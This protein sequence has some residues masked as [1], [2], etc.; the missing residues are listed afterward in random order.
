MLSEGLKPG[1]KAGAY[2]HRDQINGKLKARRHARIAAIT[3]GGAIPELG[4]Y[5]VVIEG[6]GKTVGTVDEDFAIDSV[7]GNIFL[8]GNTS[9]RITDITRDQV[10]VVDAHGAPPNIPFWFGEAPGRTV[11]LSQELSQLRK[12]LATNLVEEAW[13]PNEEGVAGPGLLVAPQNK[14]LMQWLMGANHPGGCNV[15]LGDG[16]VRFV[17]ESVDLNNVLL[18]LASRLGGEVI[19][20][21]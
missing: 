15:A 10:V 19:P 1:N 2:L 13:E 20:S 18:P 7:V 12:E 14:D 9:W 5:K 21:F 6:E 4:E 8:L 16:S 3:C 11:E 17:S